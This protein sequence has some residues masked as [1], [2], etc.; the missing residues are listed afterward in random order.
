M[1]L[2][3]PGA[4]VAVAAGIAAAACGAA[5]SA[6]PAR[7]PV[8]SQASNSVTAG[9]H[10]AVT[11]RAV[12]RG[13]DRIPANGP[14]SISGMASA[15]V[16]TAVAHSPL[17]T[18]LARAIRRAGLTG[19]LNSATSITVFAPEDAAFTALGPGNLTTLLADRS[20]LAKT[21]KYHIV[22]GRQ[23]PADLATG[24]HLTT[25]LGTVIVPVKTRSKYRV[26]DAQ[27]VCGNI[28]TANAT[29]YIVNKVL[30]PIP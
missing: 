17:L 7:T 26:N 6:S 19:R 29:I 16:A 3:V 20:D 13:C 18:E 2:R 15:P 10:L 12:G 28:Q 30:V 24:K 25:L 23:S 14:G 5:G 22:S 8:T 21:L 9:Q 4:A 11:S 1:S 27:V